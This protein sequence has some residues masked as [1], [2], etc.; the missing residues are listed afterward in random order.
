MNPTNMPASGCPGCGYDL[1]GLSPPCVCPECGRLARAF[2]RR[3]ARWTGPAFRAGVAV[4][5]AL[6]LVSIASP[7]LLARGLVA[8]RWATLC[9]T[10]TVAG[11]LGVLALGGVLEGRVAAWKV[12]TLGWGGLSVVAFAVARLAF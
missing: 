2:A 9:V 5:A 6:L 7:W 12:I 8:G 1:S 10:G 3:D 11:G 4:L